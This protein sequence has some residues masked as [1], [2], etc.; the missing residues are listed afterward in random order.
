MHS[1]ETIT[2]NKKIAICY[3]CT[4]K[5][6]S[7]IVLWQLTNKWW[8]HDNLYYFIITD[9]EDVFKN[10][11]RQNL[12]VNNI[13]EFQ[14]HPVECSDSGH[15]FSFSLYRFHLQQIAPYG[16]TN[17]GLFCADSNFREEHYQNISHLETIIN[18]LTDIPHT[19]I[20]HVAGYTMTPGVYKEDVHKP[21][22]ILFEQVINYLKT[23]YNY[24]PSQ[25]IDCLDAAVRFIN[26]ENTDELQLL[27][28]IWNSVIKYIYD[29][30][31][32]VIFKSMST[33]H[34][35]NDEFV[36]GPIYDLIG[37]K[38]SLHKQ[39]EYCPFHSHH[40]IMLLTK[41]DNPPSID[42]N[43]SL[44]ENFEKHITDKQYLVN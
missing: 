2:I 11:P 27:F 12:I 28:D 18:R 30:Q 43:I 4:T 39:N 9:N 44:K 23:K 26:F 17:L 16:I 33:G 8:D 15:P 34:I 31:E 40:M 21:Y 42:L 3:T 37:L 25:Q 14:I 19:I 22:Q 32:G 5:I 20:N 24:Q 29:N 38:W 13:N 35:L 36:L 1:L 6:I 41:L 10:C 7:E